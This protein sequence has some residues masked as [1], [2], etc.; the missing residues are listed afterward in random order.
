MHIVVSPYHLTTREAP[1]LAALQLGEQVVTMMPTPSTGTSRR[2]ISGAVAA[3]PRYLD[4]MESWRWA[5]DLWEQGVIT[6]S[7]EGFDPAGDVRA[8]FDRISSDDRYAPLRPLMKPRVF[9]DDRD[10]LQAIASDVL[11]GG[12]D[13]AVTVPVAAG[14]DRFASR[15]RLA[16][17][18]ASAS[19][20]SQKAEARLCQRVAACAIPLLVQAGGERLLLVREVMSSE[21]VR[22]GSAFERSWEGHADPRELEA[23][24]RAYAQTFDRHADEITAPGEDDEPR[25]VVAMVAITAGVLPGGAV[26]D[27][28]VQALRSLGMGSTRRASSVARAAAGETT[29]TLPARV[30]HDA[31]P[32][33][34]IVFR[35]IGKR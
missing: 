23:A 20:I 5:G 8:A 4:L 35:V 16:V 14:L 11:K 6:P 34:S 29:A 33:R 19:S 27:S 7:F 18:R 24:A 17:A 3:A 30:D 26:L 21:A 13:P 22:V 31:A 25:A 1:A 2:S 12:P 28:S 15:H 32:V 9:E 10:Y